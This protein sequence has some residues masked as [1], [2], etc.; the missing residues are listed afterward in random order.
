[1]LSGRHFLLLGIMA[2]AGLLSV[3]DGQKQIQLCYQIAAIEKDLR[4][5]RS[6]I[7][8]CKIKHQALQSPGA[9]ILKAAELKLKVM[10]AIPENPNGTSNGRTRTG[11][12]P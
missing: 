8:L 6:E 4:E 9:V 1:M 3:H 7:E 5:I 10:P 2:C 12:A 11:R